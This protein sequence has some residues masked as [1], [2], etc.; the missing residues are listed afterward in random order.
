MTKDK[1][2]INGNNNEQII[3]NIHYHELTPKQLKEVKSL[4]I[5]T[6]KELY[7]SIKGETLKIVEE[8]IEEITDKFIDKIKKNPEKIILLKNPAMLHSLREAQKGYAIQ[9]NENIDNLDNQLINLLLEKTNA[10]NQSLKNLILQQSIEKLP[11]LNQEHLDLL[12]IIFLIYYTVYYVNSIENFGVFLNNILKLFLPKKLNNELA[13]SHLQYLGC[14]NK[15]SMVTKKHPS[16]RLKNEY[17]AFFMKGFKLEDVEDNIKKLPNIFLRCFNDNILYQLSF[18]NKQKLIEKHKDIPLQKQ[19]IKLHDSKIMNKKE[20]EVFLISLCKELKKL[21]ETWDKSHLKNCTE[22]T[23]V[24]RC[25]A[26]SNLHKK[27][28]KNY[29]FDTWL[30][31]KI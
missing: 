24:G 23:S 20:A 27:G 3:N 2:Q 16:E 30:L 11:L 5:I 13:L 28:I 12:T 26:I 4:T 31:P 29:N 17:S 10:K 19:L 21:F 6:V 9:G 18:F 14:L 22:L 8:R 1:Q 7:L 15:M 25:L